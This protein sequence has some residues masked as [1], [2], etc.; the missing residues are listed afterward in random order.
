MI[1]SWHSTLEFQLQGLQR[2]TT[3]A[4]PRARVATWI[5]EYNRDRKHPRSACAAGGDLVEAALDQRERHFQA[6]HHVA[7]IGANEFG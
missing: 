6:W 3:R 5:D 4:Q 1:E 7:A 2:F